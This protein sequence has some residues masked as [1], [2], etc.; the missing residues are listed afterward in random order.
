MYSLEKVYTQV[1]TDYIFHCEEDWEFYNPNFIEHSFQ[2]LNDDP[3]IT[4]VYLRSYDH[5][6]SRYNFNLEYIQ[7]DFYNIVKT[8]KGT[9][10]DKRVGA[11]FFFNP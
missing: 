2:I 1:K 9:D 4:S 5:L 7:K 11:V 3:N 10:T 8:I 6:I